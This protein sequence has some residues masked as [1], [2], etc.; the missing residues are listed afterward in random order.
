LRLGV[1][2]LYAYGRILDR[3]QKRFDTRI[4]D[5]LV[6]GCN[7]D[8]IHLSQEESVLESTLKNYLQIY[9][10]ESL[11]IKVTIISKGEEEG[12]ITVEN[13]HNGAPVKSKITE[14]W[15]KS[16]ELR[17]LKRHAQQM[18]LLGEA[19][20]KIRRGQAAHEAK[21]VFELAELLDALA[22]KGQTIQRYKGLGEMNPSQLWETTMEP[23]NRSLLQVRIED[24]VE[25]DEAFSDLMGDEVE[26]RR[27]FIE[28]TALEVV[29]LDI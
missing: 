25:A 14:N 12:S 21:D 9:T 29:N 22:K 24:A 11:P 16:V 27:Q 15:L 8:T 5:A 20:F 13:L 7:V 4:I 2:A 10:P 23:E 6:Q 28:K 3:M 26:P 17:E 19:P 18:K 1:T